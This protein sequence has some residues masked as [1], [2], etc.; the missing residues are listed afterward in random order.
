[1]IKACISQLGQDVLLIYLLKV[2][3]R[4]S[5]SFLLT[6]NVCSISTTMILFWMLFYVIG[7]YVPEIKCTKIVLEK[8]RLSS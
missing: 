6:L 3:Q 4:P 8:E 1:M 2:L 7:L 5:Y